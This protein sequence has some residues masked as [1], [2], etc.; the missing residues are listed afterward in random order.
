M[1]ERQ[2]TIGDNTFTL[3]DPFLVMAT[4]NPIEHEG[5]YPL[6]EAQ[7]DRFMF[8]VLID[9]PSSSE[10]LLILKKMS[11][12]KT[13]LKQK[14][15]VSI[16]QIHM[17]RKLIDEIHIADNIK[18]YIVSLILA[19][20]NPDNYGIKDLKMLIN[21]GASPRATIFMAKAA[22]TQAFLNKR[23]YVIPDD[24]RAVGKAILRH[25]IIL[26]YEA[27]AEEISTDYIID[28]I[29]DSLPMP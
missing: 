18:E 21:L 27:E 12:I 17:A 10:E 13:E 6:P 29:Y 20:R 16:K 11:K 26:S 1:Q 5:T 7:I 22:K 19:T 4:Q 14:A 23:A 3:D 24:V 28:R 9:Y 8:K 25:R 2:I 15:I